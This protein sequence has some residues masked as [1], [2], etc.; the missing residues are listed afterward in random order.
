MSGYTVAHTVPIHVTATEAEVLSAANKV[1]AA[2]A[3]SVTDTTEF[4][5]LKHLNS[6]GYTE[7]VAVWSSLSGTISGTRKADSATQA[8]MET[9]RKAK[10]PFYIHVLTSPT[11]TAG[12]RGLRYTVLIESDENNFEAGTTLKFNYPL[13][14]SGAPV[15]I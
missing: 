12:S 7:N 4:E 13:K 6:D 9:A 3:F 11:A 1:D 14:F 5:E 10:A 8:V 2:T 15:A